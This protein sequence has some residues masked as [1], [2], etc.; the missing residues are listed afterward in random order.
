MKIL[1]LPEWPLSANERAVALV[2]FSFAD[3][4]TLTCYPTI[5]TICKRAHVGRNT[6]SRTTG[7][8]VELDL[9]KITKRRG[10]RGRYDRNLYDFNPL[11]MH[12][13]RVAG[14]Q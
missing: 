9:V 3:L 7:L 1:T 8:L 12:I 5:E 4:E 6:V 10:K 13:G 2:I 14:R 11:R